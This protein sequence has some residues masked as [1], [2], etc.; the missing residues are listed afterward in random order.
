MLRAP[1]VYQNTD[2]LSYCK[3]THTDSDATTTTLFLREGHT[4]RELPQTTVGWFRMKPELT[5]ECETM[6]SVQ[7]IRNNLS[8]VG[9]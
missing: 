8:V 9:D 2:K 5:C 3:H 4:P 6:L 1:V 7:N